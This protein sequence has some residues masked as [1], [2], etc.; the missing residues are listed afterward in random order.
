MFD[1][2]EKKNIKIYGRKYV[3]HFN[4]F[5]V[6]DEFRSCQKRTEDGEEVNL[7]PNPVIFCSIM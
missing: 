7:I 3:F 6:F 5:Y 4:F 2:M 1:K